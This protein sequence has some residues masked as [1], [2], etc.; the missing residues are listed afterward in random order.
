MSALI[1]DEEIKDQ[2]WLGVFLMMLKQI[3][4]PG[5]MENLIDL[6]YHLKRIVREA[7]GPDFLASVLNYLFRAASCKGE[8]P[9]CPSCPS[10]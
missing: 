9:S 2:I 6:T 4:N 7:S 3:V 8:A 1:P 5:I 10:W